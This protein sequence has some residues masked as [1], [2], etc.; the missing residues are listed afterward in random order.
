MC[1][2]DLLC[3]PQWWALGSYDGVRCGRPFV[4][5]LWWPDAAQAIAVPFF[6]NTAAVL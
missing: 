1:G 3:W 6:A 2:T 5:Q 4:V